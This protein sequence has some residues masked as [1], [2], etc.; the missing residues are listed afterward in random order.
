MQLTLTVLTRRDVIGLILI[1]IA[2]VL[3]FS[4]FA[5]VQSAAPQVTKR[6]F[7]NK[8]PPQVPLK[9]KIKK[10]KEEK[11]L[12]VNNKNWFR[13]IEIEVTN[14]SDKPIYFLSLNVEM[15][16]VPLESGALAVFPLRYGRADFYDQATKPLPDDVPIQPKATY[17]FVIDEK[18]RAGYEE[19]RARDN[20]NDPLKLAISI[21]HLSFGD[22][23]G[24]TSMSA[25]PFPVKNN[26]EE[27]GHCLKN[28][29]RLT[30]ERRH[31]RYFLNY[32]RAFSEHRH[33]SCR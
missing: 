2:S 29:H 10:E 20:R 11:A 13:D 18:N 21:N 25:V 12:D 15:P 16:D 1:G 17:T 30:S 22:G 7:E 14:T 33:Q 4:R 9:V 28:L 23:T 5:L 24:F 6:S 3:L 19:W 27:L 32:T 31:L 8:I 26:P